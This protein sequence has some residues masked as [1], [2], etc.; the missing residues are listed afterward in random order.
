M[1]GAGEPGRSTGNKIIRF[2]LVGLANTCIDLAA[3]FLLMKLGAP[4]LVANVGAWLVA[5]L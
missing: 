4:P 1:S 5:V 2:A 3:F